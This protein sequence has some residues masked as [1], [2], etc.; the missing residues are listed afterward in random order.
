MVNTVILVPCLVVNFSNFSTPKKNLV[1]PWFQYST[2]EPKR[3]FSILWKTEKIL[4]APLT[5]KEVG[6]W[7]DRFRSEKLGVFLEVFTVSHSAEKSGLCRNLNLTFYYTFFCFK[8]LWDQGRPLIIYCSG[9]KK[10]F[11]EKLLC[12]KTTH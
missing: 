7:Y 4:G 6:N 10:V 11:S 3:K 12:W 8:V 2:K 5:W 9:L 1:K